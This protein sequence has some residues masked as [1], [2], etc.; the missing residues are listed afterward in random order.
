MGERDR[1]RDPADGGMTKLDLA[2]GEIRVWGVFGGYIS[3][4]WQKFLRCL[5]FLNGRLLLHLFCEPLFFACRHW[6]V[7]TS[8]F[9]VEIWNMTSLEI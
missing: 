6:A 2:W 5:N 4:R 3:W 1:D 7:G 8:L 9:L